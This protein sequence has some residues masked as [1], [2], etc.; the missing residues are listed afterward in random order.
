MVQRQRLLNR[1]PAETFG[2][3]WRGMNYTA[4][5]GRFPDGRLAELFLSGG[6]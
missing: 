1:R 4:T 5:A 6:N 2:F 3:R